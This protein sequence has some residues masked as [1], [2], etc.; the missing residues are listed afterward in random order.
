LSLPNPNVFIIHKNSDLNS[1]LAGT[2]WLK[3]FE[4]FKFSNGYEGLTKY[5]TM[6]GKV[7]AI[8]VELEIALDNDLLLIAN[9][10]RINPNTKVLVVAGYEDSKNNKLYEYG[11]DE[12]V[13]VPTS[14]TD[15]SDKILLMISKRNVLESPTKDLV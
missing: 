15:I 5:R 7:D 11:T 10:K 6:G 13:L 3:G 8:V 4:P 14:P 1:L 9:M 2:F 12:I